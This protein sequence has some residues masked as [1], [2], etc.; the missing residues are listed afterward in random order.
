[1]NWHLAPPTLSHEHQAC[2]RQPLSGGVPGGLALTLVDRRREA[3]G[4]S[5]PPRGQPVGRFGVCIRLQLNH[6]EPARAEQLGSCVVQ[7]QLPA[8]VAR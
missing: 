6:S 1:M 7:T 2:R 3:A 8:Y 5:T 4:A